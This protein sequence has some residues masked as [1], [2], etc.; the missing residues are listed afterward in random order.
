VAL[1]NG[2]DRGAPVLVPIERQRQR[3][4]LRPALAVL[5]DLYAGEGVR[6]LVHPRDLHL[7]QGGRVFVQRRRSMRRGRA[8]GMNRQF[9][10][11]VIRRSFCISDHAK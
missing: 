4:T 8:V 1:E 3:P 2:R 9:K 6:E 7:P 5:P 10:S 11:K